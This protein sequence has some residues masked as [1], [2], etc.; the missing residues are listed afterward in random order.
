MQI[1]IFEAGRRL[2]RVVQGLLALSAIGFLILGGEPGKAIAVLFAAYLVGITFC[3]M[4]L[5]WIVRGLLG[6]PTGED[7]RPQPLPPPYC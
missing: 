4:A 2:L 7:R 3:A 5:G 6:I 1:N